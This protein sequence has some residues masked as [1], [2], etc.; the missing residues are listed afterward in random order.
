MRKWALIG[1]LLGAVL[2]TGCQSQ[3]W[4]ELDLPI[5]IELPRYRSD[6]D[7]YVAY[8]SWSGNVRVTERYYADRSYQPL[9]DARITVVETGQVTFTDYD[10]YFVI[11]GVPQGELT[12][13]IQHRRLGRTAYFT[14]RVR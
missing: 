10:G 4:L 5:V 12:L 1:L 14:V 11:R 7:G 3:V 13:K 2:F 9:N 6:L 8:N